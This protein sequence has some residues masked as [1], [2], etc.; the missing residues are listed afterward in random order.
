M[1]AGGVCPRLSP[2]SL[3]A[4]PQVL[5]TRSELEAKVLVVSRYVVAAHR[6]DALLLGRVLALRVAAHRF[7]RTARR[8]RRVPRQRIVVVSRRRAP[9]TVLAGRRLHVEHGRVRLEVRV[10]LKATARDDARAKLVV[11]F[12]GVGVGGCL[13]LRRF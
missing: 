11:G 13:R 1:F 12:D 4:V 3:S 10:D 9:S 6:G 5:Q 7:R 8:R 2:E